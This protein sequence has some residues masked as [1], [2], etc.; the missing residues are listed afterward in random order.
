MPLIVSGIIPNSRIYMYVWT[1]TISSS[2]RENHRSGPTRASR[3][4]FT[5]WP[6][7]NMGIRSQPRCYQDVVPQ[8][9]RVGGN[10]VCVIRVRVFCSWCHRT[11]WK[12]SLSD[13]RL[14]ASSREHWG[15]CMS[16]SLAS[17]GRYVRYVSA[18]VP[19]VPG[20]RENDQTGAV[21][22]EFK[23]FFGRIHSWS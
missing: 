7:W 3:N 5:D 12:P 22:S 21:R 6:H 14:W 9:G 4:R 19:K 15:V 10:F 11:S 16:N 13:F 23:I 20:R 8:R 2:L 18:G 1:M 17:S